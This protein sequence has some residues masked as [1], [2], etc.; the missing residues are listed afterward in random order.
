MECD[1]LLKKLV[2][3]WENSLKKYFILDREATERFA[4]QMDTLLERKS[5]DMSVILGMEEKTY[6]GIGKVMR[7]QD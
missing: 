4:A 5:Q 1:I 6:S 2:F 7:F 3:H